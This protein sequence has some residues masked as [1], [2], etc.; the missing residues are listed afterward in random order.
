APSVDYEYEGRTLTTGC[1]L[2]VVADGKNSSTRSRLGIPLVVTGPRVLLTGLLVDDGG[3]WDRAETTIGVDGRNQYIVVPR[4]DDRIRLYIGRRTTDP[5]RFTGRDRVGD[6]LEAYRSPV[7]PHHEAL[8]G[9]TPLGPCASFPM[10]DAWTDSPV[11][12]GVAL[13]GDAAGWSNPVTAQGLSVTFRDA[14][15]LADTLLDDSDWSPAGLSGYT[16]ERRDRMAR[17]RFASALTDLL[18]AFGAPDRVRRRGRMQAL[19]RDR[20]ELGAALAAVHSGPW[21]A[22]AEAFTPD[23]LTTLAMA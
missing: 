19:L 1:R 3:A 4:G 7:L 8:A 10:T 12:P 23:I 5:D 11:I 20:P 2:V 13:I 18:S 16:E 22:R 6:F 14:R 9:G 21:S 15:V 17:L